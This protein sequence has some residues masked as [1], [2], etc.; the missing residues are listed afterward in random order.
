MKLLL[1]RLAIRLGLYK[2][3]TNGCSLDIGKTWFGVWFLE[4]DY[5]PMNLNQCVHHQTGALLDSLGIGR[6]S[7]DQRYVAYVPNPEEEFPDLKS[8]PT[9][10]EIQLHH[11]WPIVSSMQMSGRRDVA[12]RR[13]RRRTSI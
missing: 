2:Y 4:G 7:G 10:E 1:H 3:H 8:I 13:R 6:L 9:V 11:R 12:G 5:Q